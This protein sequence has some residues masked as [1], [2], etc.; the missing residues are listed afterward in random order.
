MA[1][2]NLL[3]FLLYA[4]QQEYIK[5]LFAKIVQ[6]FLYLINLPRGHFV[7]TNM[8]INLCAPNEDVVSKKFIMHLLSL[9]IETCAQIIS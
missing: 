9:T 5:P 8:K 4:C 2:D 1:Q 3:H 6:F 7:Q